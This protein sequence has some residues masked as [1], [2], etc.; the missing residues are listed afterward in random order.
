MNL[1]VNVSSDWEIGCN[2]SLIFHISEDMRFFKEHT[3]NN[4]VVMGRKTFESLPNKKPLSDRINVVLTKNMNIK[5]DG[6]VICRSLDA[7]LKTLENY[8][9]ERVYVIG[10]ESIYK[11]LL[12]YC[13]T[14]YVTM[15]YRKAENADT[16]MVN[17]D[18][19]A[20]WRCESASELKHENGLSYRFLKYKRI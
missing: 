6:I 10:G 20:A 12:P 11:L 4:I 5:R 16:F 17:L 7:L 3:I 1:I 19:D 14:A 15:V 18:N 13:D 8:D 2:N 9:S